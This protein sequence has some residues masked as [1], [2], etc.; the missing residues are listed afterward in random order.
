MKY[1]FQGR[2][3][4]SAVTTTTIQN[5]EVTSPGE[6]FLQAKPFDEMPKIGRAKLLWNFRPGGPYT[7]LDS[8]KLMLAFKDEVGS[9]GLIKGV[10]GRPD[11]VICHNP[12]DFETVYRNEGV[13][14][15][16][17]IM[18]VLYYYRSVLRN[19]FFQGIEGLGGT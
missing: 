11:V 6:E 3:Q 8:D 5:M 7:N 18:L 1:I 9:I 15:N 14:P 10:F 12:Q 16:R 17:P 2:L 13:W 19:D 4:S